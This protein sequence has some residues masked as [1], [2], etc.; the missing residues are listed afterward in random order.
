MLGIRRLPN[1]GSCQEHDEATHQNT[2]GAWSVLS[3]A[4]L[5]L[6]KAS[7]VHHRSADALR[8]TRVD[9]IKVSRKEE[10]RN[11]LLDFDEGPEL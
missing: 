11:E 6:V 9:S 4:R 3:K 5:C 2:E 8:E 10:R 1:A 7:E